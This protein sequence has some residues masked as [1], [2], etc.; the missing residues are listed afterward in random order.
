MH[1]NGDAAYQVIPRLT[2]SAAFRYCF[3]TSHLLRVYQNQLLSVGSAV[4]R[5]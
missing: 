5:I 4:F 2:L 3:Q 1:R